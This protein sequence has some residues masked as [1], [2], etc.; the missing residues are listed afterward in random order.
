M[1]I[2]GPLSVLA[3][4]SVAQRVE[5]VV[6]S[7]VSVLENHSNSARGLTNHDRLEQEMWV[8]LDGPEIANCEGIVR[9]AVKD[10]DVSFIR[11]DRDVRSY[12]VS[13][14]VDGIMKK[15]LKCHFCLNKSPL[16]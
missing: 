4:A 6:E 12:N 16:D 9:E 3:R 10:V 11:R 2:E 5:A 13:K 7:W 14:A 1:H 15:R 8:A